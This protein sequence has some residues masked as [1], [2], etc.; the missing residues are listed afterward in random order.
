MNQTKYWKSF[1]ALAAVAHLFVGCS[2]KQLIVDHEKLKSENERLMAD[3][4]S[5]NKEIEENRKE[6]ADKLKQIDSKNKEIEE[7]SKEIV[8]QLKS[9]A[10]K[11]KSISGSVFIVNKRSENI[12]LALVDIV[13]FNRLAFK[14]KHLNIEVGKRIPKLFDPIGSTV[15]PI[16]TAK[17]GVEVAIKTGK[18]LFEENP[19]LTP[20]LIE[21]IKKYITDAKDNLTKEK[22]KNFELQRQIVDLII[23][24]GTPKQTVTTDEDGRFNF[25]DIG[26]N[27]TILAFCKQEVNGDLET[28]CWVVKC[29]DVP[30][31][32][33][34][35][36]S[37]QNLVKESNVAII[38]GIMKLF[39]NEEEP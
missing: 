11:K 5:K 38:E 7:K 15:V 35:I 23:E 28:F 19:G 13:A 33:K 17:Y 22:A 12:K 3:V 14:S 27:D 16:M 4:K 34:L 26:G 21:K 31:N 30:E 9:N 37:N 8:E 36:L 2:D 6:I 29:E 24:N 32:G 39:P 10:A 18:K 25:Q 20:D 1:T